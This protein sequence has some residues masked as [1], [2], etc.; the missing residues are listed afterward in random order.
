MA[1][2]ST[3][4]RPYELYHH[5]RK[6]QKWGVRNGPPYPL[7]RQKKSGNIVKD[8]IES[9]EV[10]KKINPDKQRK[11]NLSTHEGNKSY[12]HGDMEFAQELVDKLGGTGMAKVLS[13]GRWTHKE[14][15]LS[16]EVLGTHISEL[17]I[18]EDTNAATIVYSKT[19]S[20]I[21]PRKRG[22]NES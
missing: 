21:Y 17:G 9:G 6:G 14:M 10:S 8:A 11:H 15:V 1:I 18:K 3:P 19:G 13:D 4:I 22:R 2:Y 12:I 5:G 7:S 20:H 16:D